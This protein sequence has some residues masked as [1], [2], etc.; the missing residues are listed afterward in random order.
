MVHQIIMSIV[1]HKRK[2]LSHKHLS[3]NLILMITNLYG[4]KTI[5]MPNIIFISFDMLK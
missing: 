1:K 5:F 4:G 3:Y 2:D